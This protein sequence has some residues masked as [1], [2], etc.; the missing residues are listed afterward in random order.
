MSREHTAAADITQGTIDAN[1]LDF[2]LPRGRRLDDRA[3]RWR[4]ACTGSPIRHGRGGICCPPWRRRATGRWH[5]GCGAMPRRPYPRT[6]TT[7]QPSLGLDAAALHGA[8][9]GDGDAVLVGHDWGALAGYA[10]VHAPEVSWRRL[11]TLAV[12][13]PAALTTRLLLLRPAAALLVHVLLPAPAGGDGGADGRPGVH[14]PAVGRLVARLRRRPRTCPTSRTRCG[15][16]PTWA[17]PSATTGP[18]SAASASTPARR[19]RHRRRG[20]RPPPLPTLYLHG[21]DDGCMGADL[22][23]MA[24]RR[25]D[26]TPGSRVELVDGAGHFL[27]LERPDEVNGADP[28]VPRRVPHGA[29]SAGGVSGRGRAARTFA[30]TASKRSRGSAA[31]SRRTSPGR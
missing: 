14:R 29:A 23:E 3:R 4:C 9:G 7:R 10:A 16:R 13:P 1:G 20:R 22:A 21:R 28:G 24:H 27:H 5:P 18:R 6:A 12:P 8:F 17:P 31:P 15:T 19:W 25:A 30:T 2:A 11:V 26:R